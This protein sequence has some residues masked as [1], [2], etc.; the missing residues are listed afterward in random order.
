MKFFRT[1]WASQDFPSLALALPRQQ[2]SGL[3]FYLAVTGRSPEQIMAIVK[4]CQEQLPAR[5]WRSPEL[6]ED[7]PLNYRVELREARAARFAT[8]G[9][10]GEN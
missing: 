6:A 10:P 9:T 2:R 3:D 1:P 8:S 4:L 7:V 5:Q